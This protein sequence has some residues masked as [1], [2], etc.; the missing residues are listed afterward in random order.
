MIF[1]EIAVE[2]ETIRS[3]RDLQCVLGL[4]GFGKGRLISDFPNKGPKA[5]SADGSWVSRVINSAKAVDIGKQGKIRELLITERK[6]ILKSKRHFFHNLPWLENARRENDLQQFSAMIID[7]LPDREIEC[8]LDDL[9]DDR[10]PACLRDDQHV[11]SV[12]K[13]PKQFAELLLPLLRRASALRFVDPHY[14]WWDEHSRQI[15]LSSKHAKVVTA[16]ASRLATTDIGRIPK[17][18]EFHTLQVR[19]DPQSCVSTFSAEM[20][21]CLPRDW[22]A[23]VFVWSEIEDG[24]RFHARYILTDAGGVGSDYGLDEG[25]NSGDMTDI[26]LLT[27][28]MRAQR[29]EDFSINSK[30]FTLATEPL[31]FSGKRP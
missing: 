14:L 20:A 30:V 15:R 3:L 6:K 2:P 26:Y 8:Q 11:R 22:K 7:S 18:V 1:H 31:E 13:Q 5:G 12:S 21:G 4:A 9:G 27:E 19:S 24:K 28:T 25:R 29:T 10:S 16:I 23:K 17:T